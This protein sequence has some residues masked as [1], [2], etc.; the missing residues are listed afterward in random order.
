MTDIFERVIAAALPRIEQRGVLNVPVA[1]ICI[2]AGASEAEVAARFES[3]DKIVIAALIRREERWTYGLIERGARSIG[4]TPE[5]RLIAIFDILTSWFHEPDFE[6]CTFTNVL[7]ELGPA[8]PLGRA[9]VRHLNNF[10]L[11]IAALAE[12][13][14]LERPHELA[15]LLYILVKGAIMSAAEGDLDA[16][17]KVIPMAE[18]YIVRHRPISKRGEQAPWLGNYPANDYDEML[19]GTGQRASAQLEYEY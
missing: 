12:E 19:L 10:R 6:G 13:A 1:E 7:V 18:L 11:M 14:G 2:A 15:G 17:R 16:A 5:D 9:S 8:H 3:V 4:T